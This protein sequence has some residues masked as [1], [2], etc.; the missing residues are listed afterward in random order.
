MPELHI[1]QAHRLGCISLG[2]LLLTAWAPAALAQETDTQDPDTGEGIYVLSPFEVSSSGNVGYLATSSLAGTRLNT[3]LKDVAAAITVVT[4]EFMED[5][6]STD[7]EDLLVYTTS[8]EVGGLQGNFGGDPA[9]VR[10]SPDRATRIRGL[11][12]ADVTRDFFLTEIPFDSYNVAQVDISRGANSILFGLGSPAGIINYSLKTPNMQKSARVVEL[13]VDEFGSTR[14]SLDV[15]QV[16]V[17]NL[18]GVRLAGVVDNQRFSQDHK[19]DDSKRV[20]GVVR[21]TPK[22][23]EGIYTELQATYEKGKIRANRPS[24]EPPYDYISN[25]YTNLEKFSNDVGTWPGYSVATIPQ[26]GPY[27]ANYQAGPGGNWYDSLGVV[28]ADPS[29]QAAGVGVGGLEAFRQ[30]GGPDGANGS[31][32]APAN[33]GNPGSGHSTANHYLS[34]KASFADNPQAMAIIEEYEQMTGKTWNGGWGWTDTQISDPSVFNFYDES[35]AGPNNTQWSNFNAA[36]LSLRQTFLDGKLGYEVSYANQSYEDGEDVLVDT[37][38]LAIDINRLLRDNVTPN[39][40]FGRAVIVGGNTARVTEKEREDTR[41]T[42]YGNLDFGDY[43]DPE[44]W[45]TYILGHHTFTAMTSH[46]KFEEFNYDYSMYKM[47]SDYTVNVTNDAGLQ[48]VHYL[49]AGVDLAAATTIQGAHIRGLDA[50]HTPPATM[51]A[52]YFNDNVGGKGIGTGSVGVTSY[53]DNIDNM[54]GTGFKRFKDSNTATAFI[55]QSWFLDDTIVGLWSVRRDNYEKIDKVTPGPQSKYG[56]QTIGVPFSEEWDWNYAE[57]LRADATTHSWGVMVHTPKFI[58]QY[59]PWDTNISLGYNK[60]SNFQPGQLGVDPYANQYP[61]PSGSTEDYTLLVTTLDGKVSFRATKFESV[62]ANTEVSGL[63]TWSVKNRLSRAMNGLMAEAWGAVGSGSSGRA[64]TTPEFVVNKWFFGSSYDTST[65][66]APLPAGWTVASHPELLNQ[67]LRLRAAA[68]PSSPTY[69]AEGTLKPDGTRYTEPPLTEEEAEYRR[70]WFAAR[71][72][73]EWA[74]PFGMELFNSLEFDRDYTYWGGIW[75]DNTPSNMKGIGDN[76]AK[77]WEFELTMNPTEN[78]RILANVTK[79]ETTTANVWGAIGEYIDNFAP[80]ALDGWNRELISGTAIDYWNRDGFADIDAWGN[81]GTQMFGWDWFN[82]VN[83]AYLTKKEGE[84]KSVSQLRKWNATIVTAYDFTEGSL[85]GLGIGGSVRWQDKSII[86]FY[87][88]YLQDIQVW[89]D[90]LDKPI[91]SPAR[92]NVDLWVNYTRDLTDNIE[93]RIQLNV[94][95][96]FSSDEL[97]ATQAN[98]DG[99]SAKYRIASGRTWE[100]TNTF[101]F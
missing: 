51:N 2:A 82:D 72:D 46:Q 1:S 62:Q 12:G 19:N 73:E 54:Y 101:T 99:T 14:G 31:W 60:S 70:A 65:A 39:P 83:K 66:N 40:N 44:S 13:R 77:G 98:P 78:W 48:G 75:P 53:K 87:P 63:S 5:T 85:E 27:L 95:N 92:T 22:I 88:K 52:L 23:G 64:Q 30:R 61:A 71:S 67:P 24:T 84:G 20:Y 100:I 8:T 21:F 16:L 42:L 18:L 56:N 49:N 10:R 28:Y 45:A 7:L 3:E 68:D 11:D 15:D 57:G 38:R 17:E 41:A 91:H 9:K 29:A 26:Y 43:F 74:R 36:S 33:A 25:W 4:P 89:I 93:W 6:G 59:L 55:W 94:R 90:D 80:V 58:R 81:N 79:T 34:Q 69:I 37:D 35:L 96:V 97:V 32:L 86:G 50:V 76:L 47:D